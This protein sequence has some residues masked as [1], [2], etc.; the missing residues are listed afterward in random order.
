MT[1]ESKS[2]GFSFVFQLDGKLKTAKFKQAPSQNEL[3]DAIA[4]LFGVSVSTWPFLQHD[5]PPAI[6][7]KLVAVLRSRLF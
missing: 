7:Q 5:I 3:H 6:N 1:T 2:D 4:K